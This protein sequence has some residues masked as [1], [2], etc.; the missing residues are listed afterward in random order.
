MRDL[1][2]IAPTARHDHLGPFSGPVRP[3]AH[4]P[5]APAEGLAP[6]QGD[7][8][9]EEWNLLF[10]AVVARLRQITATPPDAGTLQGSVEDCLRALQDLQALLNQERGHVARFEREMAAV[11]AG[12][13]RSSR[14]RTTGARASRAATGSASSCPEP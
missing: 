7:I 4:S 12:G 5:P 10:R 3:V 13:G 2:P 1:D 14:P 9:S 11:T 6:R 8:H